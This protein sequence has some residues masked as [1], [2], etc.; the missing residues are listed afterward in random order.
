MFE[1]ECHRSSSSTVQTLCKL[2]L[3]AINHPKTNVTYDEYR[4]HHVQL[5]IWLALIEWKFHSA[6]AMNQ[7]IWFIWLT[8]ARVTKNGTSFF[9][10]LQ[11]NGCQKIYPNSSTSGYH[12]ASRESPRTFPTS[13]TY[14]TFPT[15]RTTMNTTT[16]TTTTKKITTNNPGA[17]QTGPHPLGSLPASFPAGFP[18]PA[19]LTKVP[20]KTPPTPTGPPA[21]TPTTNNRNRTPTNPS[22]TNASSAS[23]GRTTAKRFS[24][25]PSSF[26]ATSRTSPTLRMLPTP[27]TRQTRRTQPIPPIPLMWPSGP[28]P[29]PWRMKTTAHSRRRGGSHRCGWVVCS[30]AVPTTATII[31]IITIM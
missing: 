5:C 3:C 2:K 19:S 28:I 13:P 30:I 17:P 10:M 21:T 11:T 1:E 9:F 6:K 8:L 4:Q 15:G 20:T 26:R 27:S 24:Q 31:I 25:T 29:R 18:V 22:S 12:T 16:I 14:P 7:K 23:A